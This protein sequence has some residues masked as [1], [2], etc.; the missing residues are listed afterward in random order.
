MQY[1]FRFFESIFAIQKLNEDIDYA[2][3]EDQSRV[4][5]LDAIKAKQQKKADFQVRKLKK[6]TSKQQSLKDSGK[7]GRRG[8]RGG[9]K[10]AASKEKA[11]EKKGSS[12]KKG[13]K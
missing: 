11:S 8:N 3:L 6:L 13:K 5:I 2:E 10:S 4:D 1:P 12:R 9:T 7:K